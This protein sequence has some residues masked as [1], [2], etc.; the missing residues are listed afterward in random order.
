MNRVLAFVLAA[1]VAI[2]FG[3][4]EQAAADTAG[5][6]KKKSVHSV[7]DT[8]D[9]LD[10]I[11]REKGLTVFA[12]VDHAAGGQ[13]A[14]MTLRPTSLLIFGNPK[15]GTPLMQSNQTVGL[16]LPQKALA[17]E[18]ANGDVYLVYNDPS[19]LAARHAITNRADVFKKVTGALNAMTDAAVK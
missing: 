17:F 16:D 1:G 2:G 6:V 18:D 4:S 7:Q 19:Y 15:L 12:K 3:W 10:A 9:R 8:I 13:K 14:G 5:I 11:L